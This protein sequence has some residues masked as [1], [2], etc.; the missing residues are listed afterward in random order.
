MPGDASSSEAV[1]LEVSGRLADLLR[2]IV[3][4]QGRVLGTELL[5]C[6]GAGSDKFG[7]VNR[8]WRRD[9]NMRLRRLLPDENTVLE[10]SLAPTPRSTQL[11]SA[12]PQGMPL[13]FDIGQF[14][15][16]MEYAHRMKSGMAQ[17]LMSS[18]G[19]TELLHD[20]AVRNI[21][22]PLHC[23][24]VCLPA[25]RTHLAGRA[26]NLHEYRCNIQATYVEFATGFKSAH[27]R[28]VREWIRFGSST[29]SSHARSTASVTSS[30][31]SK[32]RL[33]SLLD[34]RNSNTFSM[35][36]SSGL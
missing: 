14:N 31:V 28:N 16:I 4:A 32:K 13:E 23:P 34:L 18:L 26:H 19:L 35:E 2:T 17:V 15:E 20:L 1:T 8:K 5:R 30:T 9:A 3:D 11:S 22:G 10:H 7:F 24:A 6:F 21:A 33:A 27:F 12:L 36:L 29:K 25:D